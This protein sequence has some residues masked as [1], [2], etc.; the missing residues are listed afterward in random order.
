MNRGIYIVFIKNEQITQ[1]IFLNES[2]ELYLFLK[3]H[4]LKIEWEY[5]FR[6]NSYSN[7]EIPDNLAKIIISK[8]EI[9]LEDLINIYKSKEVSGLNFLEADYKE[10]NYKLFYKSSHLHS[11]I[12]NLIQLHKRIVEALTKHESIYVVGNAKITEKMVGELSKI[13]MVEK[14]KSNYLIDQN[15]EIIRLLEEKECIQFINGRFELTLKGK[16]IDIAEH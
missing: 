16:T 5:D 13:K 4:F 11:E 9:E 2:S 15:Q 8:I 7:A 10:V 1:K 6:I 12:L 14:D 3:N